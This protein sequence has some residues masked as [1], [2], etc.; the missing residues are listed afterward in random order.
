MFNKHICSTV[1]HITTEHQTII[2][3]QRMLNVYSWENH[4]LFWWQNIETSHKALLIMAI[5][6]WFANKTPIYTRELL[7]DMYFMEIY[8]I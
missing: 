5:L 8:F 7:M 6:S 1:L 2:V 4:V 3:E